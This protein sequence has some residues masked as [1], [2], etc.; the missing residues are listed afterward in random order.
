MPHRGT[1]ERFRIRIVFPHG[2]DEEIHEKVQ[3]LLTRAIAEYNA[4]RRKRDKFYKEYYG[5]NDGVDDLDDS[6]EE[7]SSKKKRKS[8]KKVQ[9]DDVNDAEK[10]FTMKVALRNHLHAIGSLGKE[11]CGRIRSLR[12]VE[13]IHKFQ[14]NDC[15]GGCSK[16]GQFDIP[17]KS[18][19]VLSSCG[20]I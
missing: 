12:Y 19:G 4:D 13:W 7:G 17:T 5:G 10:L 15:H 18:M 14:T 9:Q 8:S 1:G 2:A 3:H 6:E 20:H 11:L 16:C